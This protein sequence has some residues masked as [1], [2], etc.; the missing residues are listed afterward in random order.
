MNGTSLKQKQKQECF[1]KPMKA[2]FTYALFHWT[3]LE[4]TW[5]DCMCEHKC[6]LFFALVLPCQP[7][8]IM[9]GW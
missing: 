3:F 7:P 4:A 2:P 8:S 6:R 5:E 9:Y 1:V